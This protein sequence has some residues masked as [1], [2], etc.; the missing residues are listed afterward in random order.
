MHRLRHGHG[1][2]LRYQPWSPRS[3]FLHLTGYPLVMADSSRTGKIHHA[4]FMGKSTI[5]TGQCSIAISYVAVYQRVNN[6]SRISHEFSKK[7]TRVS[8]F[9]WDS[10]KA[11]SDVFE[12]SKLIPKFHRTPELI[13]SKFQ[14][15]FTQKKL[16]TLPSRFS[17]V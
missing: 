17:H 1:Y 4:I 9:V 6:V 8:P 3:T 2:L 7:K 13:R 10:L 5:S 15:M 12:R 16:P 11:A 14:Q